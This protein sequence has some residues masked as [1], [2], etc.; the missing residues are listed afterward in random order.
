M[1]NEDFEILGKLCKLQALASVYNLHY[2]EEC[3]L[4]EILKRINSLHDKVNFE[5]MERDYGDV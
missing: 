1:T 2:E 3:E 4:M 5:S